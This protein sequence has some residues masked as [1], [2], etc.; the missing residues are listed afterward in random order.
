MVIRVPSAASVHLYRS[1]GGVHLLKM[2]L[3]LPRHPSLLPQCPSEV[4]L[5][6]FFAKNSSSENWVHLVKPGDATDL[7]L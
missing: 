5:I 6:F 4:P 1:Q 7:R 3:E 2:T